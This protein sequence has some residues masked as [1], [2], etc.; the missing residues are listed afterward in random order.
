MMVAPQGPVEARAERIRAF[1]EAGVAYVALGPVCGYREWPRQ[2]EAYGE[3]I[4]KLGAVR[5]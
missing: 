3:L 1:L 2:L 5:T 4:A